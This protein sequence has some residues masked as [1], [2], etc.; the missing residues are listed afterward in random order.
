MM[1]DQTDILAQPLPEPTLPPKKGRLGFAESIGIKSPFLSRQASIQKELSKAE[2]DIAK[3]QQEQKEI[4]STGKLSAQMRFGQ[5]QEA[6]MKGYQEKIEKEPLPAFIPSKD[7]AQ[8]IAGLFGL[9]GVISMLVGGSGRMSGQ[10][11]LGNM[12]GM[13]EGYR[14]GRKDLYEKERNEF[15]KNFKAMLKKHE[16]FRKE[17]ED[18]IK[19]ASTNKEEGFRAAELAATK[20]NSSI[21]M[22]QIRKGDLLGGYQIIKDSEA[23]YENALKMEQKTR[24]QEEAE[25]FRRQQSA[26]A[27]QAR[28]EEIR[29]RGE[30]KAEK[31]TQQTMMAQRAVNSLGGVASALESMKE[32]PAGTT[33]GILPNLQTKDGLLN[34]VRNNVGRKVTSREAEIL[35]TLFTGVGRNLASIEASGAA[36]GLAELSKQMQSGIY[37]NAGIDDPYKVAIKLADIRRIATENIKPAIDSGLMPKQQAETAT[38]LVERIEKA[39]PYTTTEVVRAATQGRTTLGEKAEESVRPSK[40][41][42]TEADAE[43]A[44]KAGNLKSGEKVTIG[45]Q[46]GTWE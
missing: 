25:K 4:E 7:N 9:I 21:V 37:I 34:Y 46:R 45:G 12:N 42:A 36:T 35:N 41:Y 19:L 30:Q 16:E 38:K 11:A 10:L 23:A 26:Q 32:L 20:A 24:E 8:D 39:I 2:G 27:H 3:A 22:A 18:A 1:D 17:M 31:V 40:T 29:A 14:K 15:D 13:M 33:T 44:F 28:L 43:A 5:E 6:A